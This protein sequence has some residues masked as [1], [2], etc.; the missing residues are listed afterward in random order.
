MHRIVY[1]LKSYK[2]SSTFQAKALRP[3]LVLVTF[4]RRDFRKVEFCLYVH[5]VFV[6]PDNYLGQSTRRLPGAQTRDCKQNCFAARTMPFSKP[7]Q[8][9]NQYSEIQGMQLK[10][11]DS[12]NCSTPPRST[13]TSLPVDNTRCR[14]TERK[15]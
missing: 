2:Q 11:A 4:R 15:R 1:Y 12:P 10:V 6:H 3:S 9:D 14:L 5:P 8:N 13:S 7:S